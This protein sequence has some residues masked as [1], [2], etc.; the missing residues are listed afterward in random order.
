LSIQYHLAALNNLKNIMESMKTLEIPSDIDNIMIIN[1]ELSN[2][3]N[4][5]DS[6]FKKY[7]M[8]TNFSKESLELYILFLR[9]SMVKIWKI[10][11]IYNNK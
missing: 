1:D 9:N 8:S 10:Y 11:N 5:G 6:I 3:L 2:I 7:I 4:N